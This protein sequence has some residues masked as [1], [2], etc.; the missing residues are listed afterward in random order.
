MILGHTKKDNFEKL[1]S[2]LHKHTTGSAFLNK[3]SKCDKTNKNYQNKINKPKIKSKPYIDL[4]IEIFNRDSV[5]MTYYVCVCVCGGECIHSCAS[6]WRKAVDIRIIFLN[7]FPSLLSF[8][9]AL[10]LVL[11]CFCFWLDW[12]AMEPLRGLPVFAHIHPRSEMEWANL[13]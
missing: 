8:R 3:L 4:I 9:H 10:L 13:N 6:V 11:L 7:H 12:L 5:C 2:N 1:S